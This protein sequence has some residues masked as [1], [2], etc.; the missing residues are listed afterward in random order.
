MTRLFA[1]EMRRIWS[2]RLVRL[3]I[4]S[5]FLLLAIT[6]TVSGV[7]HHKNVG[8]ARAQLVA[9][10]K[11]QLAHG[12]YFGFNCPDGTDTGRLQND[13]QTGRP[14]NLPG[15]C[16]DVTAEEM[17]DQQLQY[18]DPRFAFDRDANDVVL[19]GVVIAGLLAFVLSASSVG[20]E[21][22][23]N[24]FASLLTWEPRRQRVLAAKTTAAVVFF[25]GVG[26]LVIG[27]Q[28]AAAWLLATTRGTFERTK[29]L[30]DEL[31][32][33]LPDVGTVISGTAGRG[34]G[35][36][37]LAA[38][39]G[40][41]IAGIARSTAGAMA[42]LGG[43]LVAIEIGARS[44][45]GGTGRWLLTTNAMA[46]L[47]GHYEKTLYNE[48]PLANGSLPVFRLTAA[49]GAIVLVGVLLVVTAVHMVS[50]QRRDAT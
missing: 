42:I 33:R 39:A 40:A 48:P 8:D 45:F 7:K 37:A 36:V 31:G 25:T 34:I 17:A 27:F 1:V 14:T 6:T 49:S 38:A 21:W 28:L 9:E 24:M 3:G 35:F 50:L 15:A 23:T 12:A 32:A 29:P 2:R 44:L 41:A 13:P 20:A 47:Q 46:L 11:D 30:V 19:A 16:H 4:L 22:G 43:Y 18:N 10:M 26:V 5:V